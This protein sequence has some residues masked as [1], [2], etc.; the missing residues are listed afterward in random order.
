MSQLCSYPS[1]GLFTLNLSKIS[2]SYPYHM[3]FAFVVSED[4][5]H[6]FRDCKYCTKMHVCCTC[7]KVNN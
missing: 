5:Y 4:L 7:I 3:N 6:T 2:I 1:Q